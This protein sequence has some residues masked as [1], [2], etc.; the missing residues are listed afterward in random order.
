MVSRPIQWLGST[1]A[2]SSRRP[3]ST[4]LVEGDDHEI[5]T[6]Y[7]CEEEESDGHSCS[8]VTTEG[9]AFCVL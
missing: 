3:L 8:A 4:Q 9:G 1:Q 2:G 6:T 7:Y 5:R